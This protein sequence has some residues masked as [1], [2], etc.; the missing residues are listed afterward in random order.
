[1]IAM[2][3]AKDH[4]IIDET[5]NFI[6]SDVQIQDTMYFFMGSA[7]NR[8][9]RRKIGAFFKE[10]YD[11]FTKLFEGNFSLSYLIKFSFQ[12]LTSEK[13]AQEVEAFFK[14]KDVSKF[15]LALNQS[16][17]AIRANAKWLERA[18]DDVSEWLAKQ[19]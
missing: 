6:L 7:A 19:N 14:D 10:N 3:A 5:L 13:D 11:T 4:A 16:L 1:M 18:K 12:D 8:E 15:N 2:T 17:D 9:S